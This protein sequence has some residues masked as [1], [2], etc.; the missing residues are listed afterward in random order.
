[1]NLAICSMIFI[2][3]CKI[4]SEDL[5]D[6]S[7]YKKVSVNK[8]G[9]DTAIR[10]LEFFTNIKDTNAKMMKSYWPNGNLQ[11]LGLFYFGKRNGKWLMFSEEGIL[12]FEGTYKM[13]QKQDTQKTFY[14]NGKV[15]TMEVFS[16]DRSE[17]IFY[18]DS[19]GKVIK[20]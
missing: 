1:M 13:G 20:K 12:V 7:N 8:I 14:S 5:S 16:S 18:Y 2:N 4:K 19:L 17:A 15:S 9:K 11:A 3:S 6:Y 10:D